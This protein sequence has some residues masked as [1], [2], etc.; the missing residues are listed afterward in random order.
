MVKN[1][2]KYKSKIKKRHHRH[3]I[4]KIGQIKLSI[5][6]ESDSFARSLSFN[7]PIDQIKIV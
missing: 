5:T 6:D 2:K 7:D 3:N 4:I 1:D